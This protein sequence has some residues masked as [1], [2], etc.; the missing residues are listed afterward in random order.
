[1]ATI[2]VFSFTV[3]RAEIW[4]RELVCLP[5][6]PDVHGKSPYKILHQCGSQPLPRVLWQPPRDG[7]R[8]ASLRSP[9]RLGGRRPELEFW[10]VY[11][12]ALRS[13]KFLN[14]S[15]ANLSVCFSLK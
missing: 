10:L 11:L 2:L 13:G 7:E 12:L 5:T 9:D 8:T 3:G 4:G 1:M 15:A 6:E 14:P